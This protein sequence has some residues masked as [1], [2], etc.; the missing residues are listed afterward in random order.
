MA[1]QSKE[2]APFTDLLLWEDHSKGVS[3]RSLFYILVR[4]GCSHYQHGPESSLGLGT[5]LS[6]DLVCWI[7]FPSLLLSQMGRGERGVTMTWGEPWEQAQ[8][9]TKGAE[10]TLIAPLKAPDLIGGCT[11]ATKRQKKLHCVILVQSKM[12]TCGLAP[13]P[14]VGSNCS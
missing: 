3:V 8:W 2:W 9:G 13:I 1:P 11:T 4:S 6:E 10:E 5:S 7:E 14:M 12:L